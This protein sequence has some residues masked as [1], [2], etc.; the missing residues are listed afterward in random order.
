MSVV[1]L[2]VVFEP[3]FKP[4]PWGGRRLETLLGKPLPAGQLIGESW[5]LVDLPTDQSRVR[6]GP[7]A[8]CTIGELRQRWGHD[9]YGSARLRNGRFPLLVK[10]LD[11]RESLSIQVHPRARTDASTGADVK[12]EAWYVVHAE[13]QSRVYIGLR[14]GVGVAEVSAAANTP[15]LVELLDARPVRA[16]DSFYLPGGT[17]HALGGG[18]VVAEVQTPGETTYRLYDWGRRDATGRPRELHIEQAL[19]NLATEVAASSM[20]QAHRALACDWG[21]ATRVVTCPSFCM[22]RIEVAPGTTTRHP[23]GSPRVWIMLAGHL[24]WLAR[25]VQGRLARGDVAL[26][27]AAVDPLELNASGGCELLQVTFPPG[28]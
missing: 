7:L 15:A 5:E 12:H 18:V 8:G 16:G 24:G 27:P 26:V 13:P 20:C 3:I 4:K 22:D 19:A 17:I 28:G 25:G 23:G 21:R 14:S 11:A 9:L 1:P 2:P 6:D 10:F